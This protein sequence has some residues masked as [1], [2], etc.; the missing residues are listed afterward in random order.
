VARENS[1]YVNAAVGVPYERNETFQFG[2]DGRQIWH[3]RKNH[4]VPGME[5]N[6]P[7]KN[8]APLTQTPIGRLTNVICYDG[9]FPGL[10]RVPADIKL[11]LG[12][13]TPDMGY[14]HTM[15]MTRLRTIENGYSMLRA[16]YYGVAAAFDQYGRVVGMLNTTP[17]KAY[18]IVAGLPTKGVAPLYS[19]TGDLFAWL[20]FCAM[21]GLSLTGIVR[22]ARA[23]GQA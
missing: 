3:Y 1:V 18:T 23:T 17:G 6:A 22:P 13:D 20:C 10:T 2:P 7:F 19:R 15:R 21:L 14:V 5:P 8:D 9:D 12:M 11:V 4:P 16:D